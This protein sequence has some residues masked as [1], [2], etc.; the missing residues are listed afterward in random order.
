MITKAFDLAMLN[1][2]DCGSFTEI[3]GDIF[4]HSPWIAERAWQ[5]RPFAAIE[6]L[7]EAMVTVIKHASR[8]EQLA[9]LRAHPELAGREAQSGELTAASTTE[10]AGAGLNALSKEELARI[11]RLN[12]DY[13]EKFGF[14]FIIAVRTH[15]K[16]SI[17]AE[18]ERRL[19]ND[20]DTELSTA[21]EQ[22]FIIARLRLD[23]LIK[24]H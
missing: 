10:Q 22:V 11:T 21:L 9:L 12:V 24:F 17:F 8:D 20:I 2:M 6:S 3:L 23:S 1:T 19:A 5:A 14:P 4:E 16:Q 18:W 7:H 15:T 13:R